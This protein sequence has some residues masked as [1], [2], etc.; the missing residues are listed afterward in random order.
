MAQLLGLTIL[1]FFIT[2]VLLVPFIDFLYKIKLRRQHQKTKDIF[3]KRTPMFDKF[4][5]W[6][7]G[8][9]FGG[10]ILIILVVSILT[11]WAY[12]IL[13]VDVKAWEI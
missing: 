5:A 12:G 13:Q 8:T 10:G 11:L 2:G 3:N 1:S 6:K 9:P 4:H 7:A